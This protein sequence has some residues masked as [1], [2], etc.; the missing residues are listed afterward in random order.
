MRAVALNCVRNEEPHIA[1]C[2]DNW[3]A[4]GCDVVL[5]DNDSEDRTL[6]I[7]RGYLGRGLLSIE[8]QPWT[9]CFQ[10]VEQLRIKRRLI[11]YLDHD[12]VIHSDADEWLCPPWPG[13]TLLDGIRRVDAEGF[14]CINFVEL[15]FAPW[16]EQD[17]TFSD[18]TRRM[19]TY[20]FFAPAHPH[21][22]L[23]WRRDLEADNV[24]GAG[25]VL[26]GSGIQLYPTDFVMRHYIALSLEHAISKFVPRRYDPAELARGW[27][28]NRLNIAPE[29]LALK[30][31][32]YLRELDQWDTV[33]FDRS[34]PAAKHFWEWAP[35]ASHLGIA[36]EERPAL[37]QEI[38]G[39]QPSSRPIQSERSR[40]D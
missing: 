5:I 9:G 25:H 14:N 24:E 38:K 32:P 12:W 6:D 15:V 22:M 28:Y 37:E 31:S 11:R 4:S 34:M 13:A 10:L 16:P 40:I 18:Y 20:Y 1:H 21:R 2:L 36:R 19:K 17:F 33:D 30:P 29:R 7:G 3:R 8:R 39:D 26:T 35:P 23:A 27:F